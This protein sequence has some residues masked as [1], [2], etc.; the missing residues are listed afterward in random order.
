MI[1]YHIFYVYSSTERYKLPVMK[2]FFLG[3]ILFSVFMVS[4]AQDRTTYSISG[5]VLNKDTG[6]PVDYATVVLTATEQW[7]VADANGNFTIQNIQPGKNTISISCLGFVTDT[8]EIVITKDIPKY[9]IY[10]A[11]DNLT[12]ESVVVT[13]Q[14]NS[15]SATTSRTIDK[16]ALDHIQMLNVADATSLLPGGATRNPDLLSDQIFNIRSGDSGETGNVSFGTAVE[17]DGVRLS[18]NGSF[19]S[20]STAGV[21]GAA[22]NNVA[23]TNVES[24]E[25]ITGVP[26]VEYGDMT[27]GVVKIN[28]RK[29]RTPYIITMSTNPNM[30]QISA[31]KGFGLG[32][33]K[34]G[35]SKGIL[36]AS[37]EYTRATSDQ[38]SPYESYD[39]K[40]VQ[41]TYSNLF[42][43]GILSETPL[44]FSISA[45]GNLGG[46][47]TKADPD[48]FS[49]NRTTVR[50]NS[51]RGNF[52]FDWLLSK[53]WITNVELSGSVVYSDKHSREHQNVDWA[54]DSPAIHG[55]EEG[56]YVAQYY[57][58]NPDAAVIL[59]PRGYWYSTMCV[60]DR[61]VSYSL[62]L[63]ANWA[64]QFGD[65]NNKLKVGLDWSGDGNFGIG[66]YTENMSTAP[67]FWEY[68]YCDVPFMNNVAAYIEE[69]ITIPIGETRLNI[70][71]GLR[72]D[73]TIIRNSAYGTTSGLSP[74]F[75][76]KYTI[77]SP[78]NRWNKTVR[79]LSFRASWG[80]A[81]KLPSYS[82]L[83]PV[84]TY[85]YL[86][87]FTST[88]SADGS[89]YSA[90]YIIPQTIAYNPEL[91]W[92]KNQQAE[93]GFDIDLAG[94]KISLAAYYNRTLDAY[95]LSNDY[96]RFTYNYTS[97]ESLNACPIPAENRRF[98]V[99]RN[100]GIVTVSDVTGASED[101]TLAYSERKRFNELT[102][103][104]NNVNPITRYGLEWVVDFKRIQPINTTIRLD[105]SFYG[106]HSLDENIEAYS[107]NGTGADGEP[108]KYIGYYVGGR[109]LSNGR[110][111]SQ[112]NTNL[113]ITTNIPKVRMIVS[114][115]LEATLYKYSRFLSGKSD[116]DRSLVLSDGADIL[117]VT[118]GSIYDGNGY[119]VVYPEYYTTYDDP[120]TL[121]NFYEDLQQARRT[122]NTQR[123]SDL[124][125]LAYSTS[126]DYYY[127]KDLL[128]P[129]F[130]MNFSVTKEIGDI[131]SVSFYANNF[132]N[133]FS[134]IRST[135]TGDYVSATDYITNFYYGLTLRLKF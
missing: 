96:E 106:Y 115:R 102:Y 46:M 40:Q 132:F 18:N 36:N 119:S 107:Y 95:R 39:R 24:I 80:V 99:D 20:F 54:Q 41:L 100:T 97:I 55:T 30:K 77:L 108:Y 19:A 89:A 72:N 51:F 35:A 130:S 103:A 125:R 65:I 23:S 16:T 17:V 118:D 52:D 87:T 71:A 28:T 101:V 86:N 70:I 59:R 13:A 57:D 56:Y 6:K 129:Y 121:R 94:N 37:L 32:E 85:T 112:L 29:G 44:R 105:G 33:T 12:L 15:N 68:R 10:L 7:A 2:R 38:R 9:Q 90:Y 62:K 126:L 91:R 74:R 48:A 50:D 3:F 67:D 134:R 4:N 133:N 84:P 75:N 104:N 92:Q 14:D 122:G 58:E 42:D 117:S 111:N 43:R 124:A 123:Y 63:K 47:D 34:S 114:L 25:V 98:T 120:T 26:S 66:Q 5:V 22:V 116:G 109:S 31:S 110:E 64:R 76:L 53:K 131:A 82:I 127:N 45:S 88:S 113:T 21:S 8:K 78:K 61:P 60:D 69:N 73:N 81:A 11:E 93:I 83:Y 135:R 1:L 27:S 128:T 49:E 79:E